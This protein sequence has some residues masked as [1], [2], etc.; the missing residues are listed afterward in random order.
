MRFQRTGWSA[1]ATGVMIVASAFILGMYCYGAINDW[2]N[3]PSREQRLTA[4]ARERCGG[5]MADEDRRALEA[6]IRRGGAL[7]A[8]L[9]IDEE[10]RAGRVP[11]ER[12]RSLGNAATAT[13]PL[14]ASIRIKEKAATALLDSKLEVDA[15]EDFARQ[16][17]G[18]HFLLADIDPERAALFLDATI[19]LSDEECRNAGSDVS[20]A[21]V[22]SR[23]SSA[24]RQS[25]RQYQ[26]ELTPL[27]LAADPT[28]W[29][30][31]MVAFERAQPGVG[32]ILR[33]PT[34]GQT[35]GMAYLLNHTQVERLKQSGI[36][37]QAAIEFVG[38][39]ARAIAQFDSASWPE[40]VKTELMTRTGPD[41][42]TLFEWACADPSVMRMLAVTAKPAR[43]STTGSKTDGGSSGPPRAF[44]AS[45]LDALQRCPST[46]VPAILVEKYGLDDQSRP[47]D[48]V[49][50]ATA[51]EAIQRF[52][53][54]AAAD[55]RLLDHPASRFL[56]HYQDNAEFKQALKYHGAVLIPALSVGD[57]NNLEKIVSNPSNIHK[58]VTPD[59]KPKGTPWWTWI[60][61]GNIV[62]VGQ[63]LWQG[64]TPTGGEVAWALVDILAFGPQSRIPV[65]VGK[66]AAGKA[67]L[68]A[69]TRRAG[70]AASRRVVMATGQGGVRTAT[71]E[72]VEMGGRALVV[73][74]SKSLL[75][76]AGKRTA[77]IATGLAKSVAETAL[78]HPFGSLM[79]GVMAYAVIFPSHAMKVTQVIVDRLKAP[80]VDA[81]ARIATLPAEIVAETGRRVYRTLPQ[82]WSGLLST[83]MTV[84]LL[85]LF[86]VVVP[87]RVL[88]W[89]MPPV[90][91]L[92]IDY[93]RV[94]LSSLAFLVKRLR[95]PGSVR[96][97]T[98]ATMG[99]EQ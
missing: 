10:Q 83:V 22:V 30:A 49:L 68:S 61:G 34:L 29:D 45:A 63:E 70:Q 2:L 74:E 7:R 25:F 14:A 50:L 60:P 38:V 4:L 28:E 92:L 76:L 62:L 96:A 36:T 18:F 32:R 55:G 58:N 69:G 3:P 43:T 93:L 20:Y 86:Y 90:Y 87:L 23:L 85:G 95:K 6:A 19:G 54:E 80:I 12:L 13:A 26:E 97:K 79:T 77:Q 40:L 1:A 78:T 98:P 47:E 94:P 16:S 48:D 99:G 41:K 35:Y 21:W 67:V 73:Q 5:M 27:L 42:K 65:A 82:P 37:E 64:R 15:A 11:W 39:N 8:L 84:L 9:I 57:E 53:N 46:D 89:L 33:D 88:K 44:N 72:A 59:G 75:R 81:A 24:H 56:S 51:M 71:I 66:S 52:D 91:R 17:I 31:L